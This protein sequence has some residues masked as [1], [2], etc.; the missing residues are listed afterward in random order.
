MNMA[1]C[2]VVLSMVVLG[3]W[4][5]LSQSSLQIPLYPIGYNY[6]A[7]LTLPADQATIPVIVSRK[8]FPLL[9]ISD[10]I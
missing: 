5:Q 8:P 6:Y 4:L 7:S 1:V 2:E 3:V 9:Y 10:L